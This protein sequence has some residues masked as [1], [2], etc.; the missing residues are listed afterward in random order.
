MTRDAWWQ[1]AVLYQIYPRSFVD[2]D[3]DGIGDLT[4]IMH[5]LDHL[6][7]GTS[8]SLGVD[9]VWL[10]PFY[11]SPQA[12]FGYDV[13][14]FQAVD[15]VYG[16]LADFDKLVTALHDRG[17]RI[18]VDLVMNHTSVAH[19][20][21]LESRSSRTNSKRG[22]YIWAGPGQ[23]GGPPN[24]WLSAFEKYGP[25]WTY[26]D[27]TGEYYL[28]SFTPG[29]PDLNWRNPAVRAAMRDV[30]RFWLDRGVDGFRVDVAHRLL[31]DAQL[32]D[33]PPELMHAR[34][35][36]SHPRLRQRN[37]DLPEVHDVLK[38]LRQ[39]LDSYGGRF[40][41]GEV[42][43]N[44]DARLAEYFG[45][46]GMQTAFHVAF[47]EQPWLAEA[48]RETVDSIISLAPAGALPTYALAT[49]D[50]SRTVTRYGD[51]DCA[52]VAATMLLTLRGIPCV[53]YGEEIGLS[54]VRLP[55]G[56][57]LDIDG[58]DG[59][60]VP[61]HW[62]SSGKGFTVGRPW[63][64]FGSNLAGVN[65][66]RQHADPDSL[67][68]LYRRLIWYR[69]GSRALRYGDYRSVDGGVDTFCFVRSTPDERLLI[70]L[71]F[72]AEPGLVAVSGLP[73]TGRVELSTISGRRGVL[74]DLGAF[75]LASREGVIVRLAP[76]NPGRRGASG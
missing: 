14:D 54:D 32:R 62:D 38:E 37:L 5:Q 31:K 57:E 74:V 43:I 64:P 53:Y 60:R 52:R 29:Q 17:M 40:A 49:H 68:N 12:D 13:S 56:Q 61:M 44:N 76:E 55:E 20:W 58:R 24:N 8:A 73:G 6:N 69:R 22:W 25:A 46:E 72:S 9:A 3:G 36:V 70:A 11:P 45:G 47:W 59:T 26:D 65:V 75:P 28:H 30:W 33:N 18:V 27:L 35:Y 66:A 10:S 34:R 67:L 15:P 1:T 23:G 48:F 50:I 19:P 4:G 2:S 16:T 7:D 41:L 63:L 51:V 71:N 39:V 21:F 42:P